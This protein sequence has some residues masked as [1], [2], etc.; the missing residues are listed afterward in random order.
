VVARR[1]PGLVAVR[2][3]I[4][5]A[6]LFVGLF[7]LC[8]GLGNGRQSV[9]VTGVAIVV[10]AFIGRLAAGLRRNPREWSEGTGLV[11]DVNE[12]PPE[13]R[14]GRCTM[15]LVVDVAGLPT[16]TVLVD[17]ARVAV[18]SWPRP[19][20]ELPIQVAADDVHTVKVLWR[21]RAGAAA[22]GQDGG[23]LD[24]IG[25]AFWADDQPPPV[26]AEPPGS[27]RDPPPET[28]VIDF[29]LDAP[30]VDPLRPVPTPAAESTED[31]GQ[32]DHDSPPVPR[33]RPSPRPRRPRLTRAAQA[34]TAATGAA[35]AAA[36]VPAAAAGTAAATLEPDPPVRP[37]RPRPAVD[38]LVTTYPSAHPGPAGA[39]NG[40]GVTIVVSD[41]DRSV[42]FY[43][44]TLGFYEVDGGE[45]NVVLAS[46]ET[47]LLLRQAANLGAVKTRLV[48]LN[49]EVADVDA[50]YAELKSNGIRFT[51][52]PKPVNRSARL[53]LWGAAFQDP[54]GHG[55][56]ITQWRP[57]AGS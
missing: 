20:Q 38:D 54:D 41:L 36:V 32:V 12:P 30:P 49:L 33:P 53:E 40:V 5:G 51:Y 35:A 45:G 34:A 16:E 1:R 17:E 22:S 15:H 6:F 39:I 3:I 57:A 47:R 8:F 18:E 11:V 44:D 29:D 23:D 42:A 56:A 13:S 9:M 10:L 37:T 52:P 55:I 28:A 14:Y 19:G 31:E 50:M 21:N 27:H 24:G 2:R 48:H 26:P 43:R 25:E 7:V 46:G 4:A